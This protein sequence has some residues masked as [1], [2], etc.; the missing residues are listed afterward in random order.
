MEVFSVIDAD[1]DVAIRSSQAPRFVL[2][3]FY[4]DWCSPC[5]ALAPI[6]RELAVAFAGRIQILSVNVRDGPVAA[7]RTGVTTVPTLVLFEDGVEV[8][9]RV[10][11]ASRPAVE[12]WLR[13]MLSS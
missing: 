5:R 2:V 13:D 12:R 7:L 8:D 11:A 1:F 4:T 3:D 6:V 9:R 10:G